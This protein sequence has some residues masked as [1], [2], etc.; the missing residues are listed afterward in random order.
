MYGYSIVCG[1]K[2]NNGG[3]ELWIVCMN[4]ARHHQITSNV[5]VYPEICFVV[6]NVLKMKMFVKGSF[7]TK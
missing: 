5:F 3:N 7:E 1:M 6:D 4:S 2:Q